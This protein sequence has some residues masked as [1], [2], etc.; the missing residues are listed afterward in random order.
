[1]AAGPIA[2]RNQGVKI[3]FCFFL[4]LT[5]Q[6]IINFFLDATIYVGGLDDKVSETLL[7]ELFVQGGPVGEFSKLS[8]VIQNQ[9]PSWS[10]LVSATELC[11]RTTIR[12]SVICLQGSQKISIRD[13]S[14]FPA[15][16]L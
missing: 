16:L 2:E 7:W 10:P 14:S 5:I 13:N 12:A 4:R 3:V 6:L 15:L 1:M 9:T 8:K 11:F